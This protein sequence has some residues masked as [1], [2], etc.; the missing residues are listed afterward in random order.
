MNVVQL[1]HN[2]YNW[3]NWLTRIIIIL[4]KF[5]AKQKVCRVACVGTF[6]CYTWSWSLSLLV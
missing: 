2:W 3:Y 1:A 4:I 6:H 5:P